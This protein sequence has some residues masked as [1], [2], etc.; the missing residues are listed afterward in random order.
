MK[1]LVESRWPQLR[2]LRLTDIDLDC[3]AIAVLMQADWPL[4][5]WMSLDISAA[6]QDVYTMLN[7]AFD[8]ADISCSTILTLPRH[9]DQGLSSQI[10]PSLREVW[11][12]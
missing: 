9:V 5:F 7:L 12:A 2:A 3:H 4:L 8:K 10:W 11:F 1:Y 6:C